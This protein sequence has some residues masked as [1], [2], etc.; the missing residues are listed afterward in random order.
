M[1]NVK[2][3]NYEGKKKPVSIR[4]TEQ[5]KKMILKKFDSLQAFIQDS[6]ERLKKK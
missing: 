2:K 4:L 6:L 3:W 1:S 5:E